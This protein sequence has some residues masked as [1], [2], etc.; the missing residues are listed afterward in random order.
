MIGQYLAWSVLNDLIFYADFG[1][2]SWIHENELILPI[3]AIG[4]NTG[5]TPTIKSELSGDCSES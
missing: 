1:H 2:L 3:A 5:L 4:D